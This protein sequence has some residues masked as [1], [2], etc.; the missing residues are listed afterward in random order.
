MTMTDINGKEYDHVDSVTRE[1]N[2]YSTDTYRKYGGYRHIPSGEVYIISYNS[3]WDVTGRVMW[4]SQ[5]DTYENTENWTW[6]GR[7]DD[8]AEHNCLVYH[9]MKVDDDMDNWERINFLLKGVEGDAQ[10]WARG[11]RCIELTH[12]ITIPYEVEVTLTNGVVKTEKAQYSTH[13]PPPWPY[14]KGILEQMITDVVV[15]SGR[16]DATEY[17]V[18]ELGDLLEV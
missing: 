10:H 6:N 11:G 12:Y 13:Y 7:G 3:Y 15:Q 16:G 8:F 9:M 14:P 2:F 5:D 18:A 1:S 4:Y 17:E